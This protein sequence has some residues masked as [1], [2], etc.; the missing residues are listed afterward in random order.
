MNGNKYLL[1]TNT[2]IYILKDGISLPYNEYF[3]S[4][5]TEIEL[6][7]FSKLSK[8][9]EIIIK[10]ALN[11]FNQISIN[12]NVKNTTIEIRKNSKIKLPDSLII[13]SALSSNSILV[14]SDKQLLNN[15]FVKAIELKDIL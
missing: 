13:A 15:D 8:D 6:L 14:T 3:I 12:E 9:D 2:I 11:K 7:S 10:E 5:I 1:D 4:I